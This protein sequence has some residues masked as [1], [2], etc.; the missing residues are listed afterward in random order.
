MIVGTKIG[1]F[2]VQKELGSGAMGTVYLARHDESGQRVAMKVVST[3]LGN[4]KTAQARF[5]READI[6]KQLKH[7]NIVRLVGVGKVRGAP[8]YAMEFVE[9]ESMD[10]VLTRRKRLGWEEVVELGQQLCAALQHAHE[11]GIVHRDLK[12]SN[13]MMLPDGT[14][15]LMDFGIA[16]DLDV[17][18]ITATNSTVGTAAYMSPEQCRGVKEITAKT[19][20]YS[21]GV[22]L[23]EF[24]TGNKPFQ[25]ESVMEMFVKHTKAKVER[26]SR[27]VLDIPI[28]LDTL[29]CQLMEKDPENR[30]YDA[31]MVG[32]ALAEVREKAQTQVSAGV[33]AAKTRKIDRTAN[34][35]AMDATDIDAARTLLGKK[36]KKKKDEDVPFFQKKWFQAVCM[37]AALVVIAGVFY[38]AFIRVPGADALF[39]QA[40]SLM[41]SDKRA[42]REGPLQLFLNYYP[43]HEKAPFVQE[44]A[45]AYDREL[46]ER[47]V[48]NR[49]ARDMKIDSKQEEAAR[50]ALRAEHAGKLLDARLVW[51]DLLKYRKLQKSPDRAWGLLAED[52]LKQLKWI[53]DQDAKLDSMLKQ[54]EITG[55]TAK[56]EIAFEELAL[57]AKRASR[58]G[59]KESAL[60]QW[61]TLRT[62]AS[63]DDSQERKWHLLAA[64]QIHEIGAKENDQ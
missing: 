50:E 6:L 47:Q 8:F 26:P 57:T 33:V 64:K 60:K 18:Q 9:G 19:D 42:A 41:Q 44:M 23:Y 63:K 1:P 51:E 38:W 62:K 30:P 3:A 34:Q 25:A 7:R 4:S 20:L 2:T 40:E 55:A 61:E 15:K 49:E 31:A 12:P 48:F 11:N 32:K 13:L 59:K 22:V 36:K 52:H 17:T 28:W 14:L 16:K 43:D 29:I 35:T 27:R 53:D 24:L 46:L 45:D 21:L 39:A 5:S 54:A 58:S 56:S 37:S 10:Q